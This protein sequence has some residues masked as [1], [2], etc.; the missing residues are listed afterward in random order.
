MANMTKFW[1]FHLK[2]S[3]DSQL[4][5]VK[6]ELG[7]E[8]YGKDKSCAVFFVF[9]QILLRK[10]QNTTPQIKW[11][12]DNFFSKK[13]KG[14]QRNEEKYFCFLELLIRTL[15]QWNF[16]RWSFRHCFLLF[17]LIHT[18]VDKKN[19]YSLRKKFCKP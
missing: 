18:V 11:H 6:S 14:V 12:S 13:H 17:S 7:G 5:K 1:K 19:R 4:I 2:L 16:L 9:L 10:F 8:Q 15:R 3:F